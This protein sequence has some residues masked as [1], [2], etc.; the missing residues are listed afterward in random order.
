VKEA[1]RVAGSSNEKS[2]IDPP[3]IIIGA[4]A[5]SGIGKVPSARCQLHRIQIKRI[6]DERPQ[7]A[8]NV[9]TDGLLDKLANK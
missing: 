5:P 1:D 7:R 9:P 6:K 4:V 2:V 3:G 8:A